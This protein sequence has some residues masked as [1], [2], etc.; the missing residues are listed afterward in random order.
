MGEGTP[1]WIVYNGKSQSKMDDDWGY[2]YGLETFKSDF[3]LRDSSQSLS[4]LPTEKGVVRW[5]K[6]K[7]DW[8]VL[9]TPLKNISQ[10][11]LFFPIYGKIKMFQTTNQMSKWGWSREL[12]LQYVTID[13]LMVNHQVNH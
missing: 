6:Y 11:G 3:L 9:S 10:L 13:L 5:A 7:Y 12:R 4:S 1:E 2:P 8:L